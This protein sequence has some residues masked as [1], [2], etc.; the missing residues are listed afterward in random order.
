[1]ESVKRANISVNLSP[2]QPLMQIHEID[3]SPGFE[4]QVGKEWTSGEKEIQNPINWS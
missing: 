2:R 4:T 1:M 3:V